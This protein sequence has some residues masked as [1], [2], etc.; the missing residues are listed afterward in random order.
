MEEQITKG[1]EEVMNIIRPYVH[2]MVYS[3]VHT[4]E[5]YGKINIMSIDEIVYNVAANVL[6]YIVLFAAVCYACGA[7]HRQIAYL[8]RNI[9]MSAV[10]CIAVLIGM[11]VCIL[12]GTAPK[13]QGR[14]KKRGRMFVRYY[15][16]FFKMIR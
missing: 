16:E 5:D 15:R 3:L 14:W 10:A 1:T 11:A 7:Y 9:I 4:G 12:K 13:G 6:L 2:R 8:V